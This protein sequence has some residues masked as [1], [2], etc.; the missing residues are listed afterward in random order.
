V[1][2]V[3]SFWI[4][5]PTRHGAHNWEHTGFLTAL[6][7]ATALSR[8]TTSV[9]G[10]WMSSYGMS[11]LSSSDA[12]D[13]TASSRK[14]IHAH[15]IP[16]ADDQRLFY[17]GHSMGGH[18]AWILATLAPNRAIGV[19]SAAG[20]I[21]KELYGD[22]NTLW[23]HDVQKVESLKLR[24]ILEATVIEHQVDRLGII[25]YLHVYIYRGGCSVFDLK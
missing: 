7:A 16:K 15:T 10:G 8:L 21:S 4:C 13:H 3:V 19:M 24:E 22:S 20:W 18:G 25:I 17:H 5:A 14:N 9:E 6:S 23:K 2:V 12:D 1:F 11:A